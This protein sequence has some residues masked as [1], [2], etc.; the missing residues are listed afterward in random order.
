[1]SKR[2]WK[3]GMKGFHPL[4]F[5]VLLAGVS[6]FTLCPSVSG[7]ARGLWVTRHSLT[8]PEKVKEM[9]FMASESN[10]NLLLVQVYARG[11]AFYSSTLVPISPLLPFG[12]DPLAMVLKM[13]HK[14]GLEV[15]AWINVF[16]I[17]SH[18]PPPSD[19][20]HILN[21]N[22]SWIITD[23]KGKSLKDYS[24]IEL[25]KKGLVG[26]FLSPGNDE[27][28]EYLVSLV[29]EIIKKYELDG[30]HLDYIRYPNFEYGYDISSRTEFMRQYYLD[31]LDFIHNGLAYKEFLGDQGYHDLLAKWDAWRIGRVT[32]LVEAISRQ[33]MQLNPRVKVSC[34]V[35]PNGKKA[36]EKG[37]DWISWLK[38]RI[39]DFVVLMAYSE[40]DRVVRQQLK[41]ALQY[42]SPETIYAGIGVYN[43]PPASAI[44]KIRLAKSLGIKGIVLFSYD[45][46][47]KNK[48][49]FKALRNRVFRHKTNLP[50]VKGRQIS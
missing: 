27:V 28:Q 45:R 1:M 26:A 29:S 44:R 35:V 17:W 24:L 50:L 5:A 48:G 25:K 47:A 49:Y 8:S 18:A 40:N 38:R 43:Q 16:Y 6:S 22:P 36:Q 33:A 39:V 3:E 32:S 34:A 13:A 11:E 46:I 19:P 37:Q 15:Y 14:R 41:E 12:F 4:F 7:E 30:I 20:R 2:I 31:P 42:S 21:S 23:R 9:I 10:F